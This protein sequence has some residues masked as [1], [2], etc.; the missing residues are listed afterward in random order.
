MSK[1]TASTRKRY[2]FSLLEMMIALVIVG[3]LMV[4]GGT[5]LHNRRP[6]TNLNGAA[7]RVWGE[8]Q[9]ARAAAVRRNAPVVI[10]WSAGG[11]T[12]I[13][14]SEKKANII[15]FVDLNRDGVYSSEDT[16]VSEYEFPKGVNVDTPGEATF[17][18]TPKGYFEDLNNGASPWDFVLST[19]GDEDSE[20][21]GIRVFIP[22]SMRYFFAGNAQ[23][24]R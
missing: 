9:N 18:F 6:V 5:Y 1:K 16:L 13:S 20:T 22:G 19:E 15:T 2:G 24:E 23:D 7:T 12:R 8:L 10:R 21:R 4:V 14:N 11:I 17:R 3:I